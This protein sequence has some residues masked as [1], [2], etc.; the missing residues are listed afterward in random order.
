MKSIC[1]H[2]PPQAFVDAVRKLGRESR[3]EIK[4]AAAK[5]AGRLIMFET[6]EGEPASG[7]V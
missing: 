6:A 7:L 3:P 2:V 4:A 5:A 1:T